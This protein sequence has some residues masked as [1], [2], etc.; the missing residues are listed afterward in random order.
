MYGGDDIITQIEGRRFNVTTHY[1][2]APENDY[3]EACIVSILQ[4][5]VSQP[6][7]GDILVFL[8]GQQDIEAVQEGLMQRTRSLGRKIKELLALPLY[9]S[10]PIKEQQLVREFERSEEQCF[11][12]T[13]ENVRKVVLATN[14]AETSLT[15]DNICYVVDSG[16]CKQN[17]YNPRSGMESLIVTPISKVTPFFCL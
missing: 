16:L 10:L 3:I 11:Q 4:I 7:P 5:H 8:T 1:L 2:K 9:S 13:P 6:L 15:I 12:P 17:S 14:V